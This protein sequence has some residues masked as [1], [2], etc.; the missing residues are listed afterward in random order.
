MKNTFK[1][2]R[3]LDDDNPNGYMESDLDYVLNNWGLVMEFLE[4]LEKSTRYFVCVPKG[5]AFI[6]DN[7]VF[8]GN[9]GHLNDCFG[10][11]DWDNEQFES[12]CIQ[13]KFSG[14]IYHVPLEKQKD[15]VDVDEFPEEP[16]E[17]EFNV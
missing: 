16:F 10:G 17:C 7:L 4:G 3:L 14:R 8:V 13:D 2:R 15:F 9:T 6:A 5:K 11:S 12:F 1:P